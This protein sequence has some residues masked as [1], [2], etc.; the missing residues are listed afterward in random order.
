MPFGGYKSG[1][2]RLGGR[3]GLVTFMQTKNVW[4]SMDE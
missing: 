4:I 2:G 1:Y 3:E